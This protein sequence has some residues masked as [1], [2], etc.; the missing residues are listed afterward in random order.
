MTEFIFTIGLL[1]CLAASA[2]LLV[3]TRRALGNRIQFSHS[4]RSSCRMAEKLY[5]EKAD[6]NKRTPHKPDSWTGWKT[7][8]V[9]D[10]TEETEDCRSI[11]LSDPTGLPLSDFLPG[12]FVMIGHR[13]N[14]GKVLSRCYSLSR[15]HDSRSYRITVKRVPGGVMSKYLHRDIKVGSTLD[16]KAPCGNFVPPNDC[17]VPLNLIAAGIGITPMVAIAQHHQRWFPSRQIRIFYQVRDLD[18]A[19]LLRE[20][21]KWTAES[22]NGYLF[23]FV[24][25]LATPKPPWIA[26]L[27]RLRASDI[28]R[29]LSNLPSPPPLPSPSDLRSLGQFLI[30][31]PPSMITSLK[32]N[33]IH[34]GISADQITTEEFG[35]PTGVRAPSS[36]NL[37]KTKTSSPQITSPDKTSIKA[38]VEAVIEFT[39]S[40]KTFVCSDHEQTLL[41]AAEYSGIDLDTGCRSGHCGSCL[42]KV[43][44]GKVEYRKPPTFDEF[45]SNEALACVGYP[46]GDVVIDR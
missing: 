4:Y 41:D 13:L 31:A 20:L 1:L 43:L 10:I 14:D 33:L 35:E 32:E 15:A 2:G 25:Q 11:V 27:G 12:Q 28:I 19:P 40:G 44:R 3:E 9:S 39:R 21:A 46:S 16:V 17:T 22:T 24:S 6:Q 23:I 5:W 42:V 34:L 29:K 38:P 26:G 37:D 30:C 36:P 18:H 7:L 45:D 8:T